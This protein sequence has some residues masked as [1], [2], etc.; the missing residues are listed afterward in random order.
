MLV[1]TNAH[2]PTHAHIFTH[3]KTQ[4]KPLTQIHRSEELPLKV[5]ENQHV[6]NAFDIDWGCF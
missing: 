4:T 5:C 6:N 1:F 2:T 3:N